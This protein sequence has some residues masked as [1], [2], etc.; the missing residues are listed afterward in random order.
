MILE[1][2]FDQR[3]LIQV[4]AVGSASSGKLWILNQKYNGDLSLGFRSN[5]MDGGALEYLYCPLN[6]L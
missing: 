3:L 5:T 2:L 6:W 4:L 1:I